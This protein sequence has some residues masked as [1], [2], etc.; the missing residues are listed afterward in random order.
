MGLDTWGT[1][2]LLICGL[3]VFWNG[4][5]TGDCWLAKGRLSAMLPIGVCAAEKRGN[6]VAVDCE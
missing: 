1:A 2:M 5:D 3:A 6:W 4:G